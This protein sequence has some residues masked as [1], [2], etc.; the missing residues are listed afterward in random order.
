MTE[1]AAYRNMVARA[2]ELA[3]VDSA[4]ALLSWDQETY[5]PSKALPFRAEQLAHFNGWSH[6]QFTAPEVGDW[7]RACEDRGFPSGSDELVNVREW[8]RSY[9]RQTRIP[10]ELVEE[11]SRASALARD[12]WVEARRKSEFALF[13]PHLEH[14]LELSRRMADHWGYEQTPYD[15]LLDGHERNARASELATMF[16]ALRPAIVAILG[17][18]AERSRSIP[19]NFLEGDYPIAGQQALN[20]EVAAAF[21]FDF[22]AG[23]VDTTTHPFCTGLG[24]RDCR[25]TTR[26][27]EREFAQSLYGVLHETGHGLYDQGLPAQHYGTPLA[28]AASMGI[29]ESQSRLWENHVGRSREFWEHWHGPACRHLPALARFSPEQIY[30]AVNRVAPSFIRVEADQVTYDLHIL[31][32]F[33]LELRL[34]QG[35]LKV[36]DLPACWNEEFEKSFGLK[37]PD[38]ARGCLQDIHW[39][40]GAFGYFPTYTLGNLNAAQLMQAARRDVAGLDQEL[41]AGRYAPLLQWLR[42]HI[43]EAGQ[44]HSPQELMRLAT[45]TASDPTAHV[46]ALR[47]R[48]T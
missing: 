41:A 8:R 13:Q 30:F 45:G 36:A 10:A 12:A 7:I 33:E 26:Y 25:L 2:R 23:R 29:H 47:R 15:A 24:P 44:R 34:V 37:V 17:P 6:R 18:A 46:E 9:D 35:E 1:L 19:E 21:G 39:S 14:L 20:R 3:L 40:L 31:L 11:F 43:H 5:M 22:E 42:S 4:A 48:F 38:D 32:R 28:G 16:S 27:N